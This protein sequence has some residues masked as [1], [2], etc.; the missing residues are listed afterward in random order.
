MVHFLI[1][2]YKDMPPEQIDGNPNPDAILR[3]AI[4]TITNYP[5]TSSATGDEYEVIGDSGL[6]ITLPPRTECQRRN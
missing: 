6:V 3:Q 4:E 5:T 1:S 2:A